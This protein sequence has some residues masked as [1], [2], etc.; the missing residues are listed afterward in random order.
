MREQI[1]RLAYFISK[2][3][4]GKAE[5]VVHDICAGKI[6]WIENG[7]LTNRKVGDCDE[8]SAICLL[9]ETYKNSDSPGMIVGYH[10]KSK[11]GRL[12]R[13]SNL[14]FEDENHNLQFALC[15]NEDM[16]S[17]VD[18]RAYCDRFLSTYE[19]DDLSYAN[20]SL[21]D[22]DTIET[23][24]M[25]VI[26]NEIEKAKPFS[27]DSKE[28]KIT[29]L[30]R[31]NEKGIFEVRHAAIKVGELLNIAIP[32]LYKYL[33]EIKAKEEPTPGE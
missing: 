19:E 16:T 21:E 13:S 23:L 5:V 9:H 30:K 33:K 12:L 15:V 31:L 2:L 26:L 25:S 6:I 18:L 17:L 4:G 22:E 14:F 20:K 8:V 29:I 27:L 7:E 11:N 3:L 10:S 32:T 28:A 1:I 24:T